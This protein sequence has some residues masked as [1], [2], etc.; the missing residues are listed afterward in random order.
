M[1]SLNR[2][3]PS[4]TM[5]LVGWSVAAYGITKCMGKCRKGYLIGVMSSNPSGICR[6]IQWTSHFA[7]DVFD[8]GEIGGDVY[9]LGQMLDHMSLL[10]EFRGNFS[11]SKPGILKEHVRDNV[12]R[13]PGKEN[14]DDGLT[15]MRSEILHLPSPLESG[16][17]NPSMLR[18]LK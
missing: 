16:I 3:D 10:R 13:I 5:A 7:R 14:H 6:I 11:G 17:Y 12:L 4:G 1:S 9:E 8:L 15:K 18:M 2:D